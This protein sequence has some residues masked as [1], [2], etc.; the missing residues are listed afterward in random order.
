MALSESIDAL[1][2]RLC[3]NGLLREFEVYARETD[4]FGVPGRPALY[5]YTRG[6]FYSKHMRHLA[7]ILEIAGNISERTGHSFR[8][9]Q[10]DDHAIAGDLI[11]IGGS[12]R[13]DGLRR[14][15]ARLSAACRQRRR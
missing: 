8:F 4:R 14:E 15:N 12:R 3:R 1:R 7:E 10:F 13:A 2:C 9:L 11:L 6:Y 5:A